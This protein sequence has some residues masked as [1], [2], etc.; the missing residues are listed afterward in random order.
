MPRIALDKPKDHRVESEFPILDCRHSEV[1]EGSKNGGEPFGQE[2]FPFATR[3]GD[4]GE[5]VPL[6]RETPNGSANIGVPELEINE[7]VRK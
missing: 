2:M 3:F 4:P 7:S 5:L 6:D 1:P